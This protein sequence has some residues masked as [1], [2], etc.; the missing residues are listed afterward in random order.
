MIQIFHSFM[1]HSRRRRSFQCWRRLWYWF[2][3][4]SKSIFSSSSPSLAMREKLYVKS[5]AMLKLDFLRLHTLYACKMTEREIVWIDTFNWYLLALLEIDYL[6]LIRTCTRTKRDI[7]LKEGGQ[8]FDVCAYIWFCVNGE[9]Q[10][11]KRM[12]F[13]RWCLWCYW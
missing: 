13:G 4:G 7:F 2:E 6:T 5:S 11:V 3:C 1:H 8:S 12:C 9:G 10:H